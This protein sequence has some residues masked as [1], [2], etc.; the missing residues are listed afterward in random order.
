M[1]KFSKIALAAIALVASSMASAQFYGGLSVGQSNTSFEG[2]DFTIAS[3]TNSNVKEA[4]AYKVSLG[5]E[6]NPNAAVEVSYADLGKALYRYSGAVSGESE[7]KQ[8]STTVALK[9]TL[10]LN[11]SWDLTGKLGVAFN[12]GSRDTK[13]TTVSNASSNTKDTLIGIG[14]Q[15][16]LDK[17]TAIVAEYEDFGAFG[18]QADSN[19]TRASAASVGLIVKF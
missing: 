8:S 11:E 17:T 14:V 1:K 6:L 18:A 10:P 13:G 7:I 15:Y 16:N 4:N 2:S 9:G 5:Y 3:A 12:K 19:R